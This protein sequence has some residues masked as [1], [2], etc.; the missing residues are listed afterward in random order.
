MASASPVPACCSLLGTHHWS[1]R[2]QCLY[3][4]KQR[5]PGTLSDEAAE[6][7]A[8]LTAAIMQLGLCWGNG[9]NLPREAAATHVSS[10]QQQLMSRISFK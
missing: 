4:T 10:E 6:S 2:T 1:K 9:A 3:L 8:K 5:L 7:Q